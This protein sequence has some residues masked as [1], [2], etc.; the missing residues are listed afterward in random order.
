M[1]THWWLLSLVEAHMIILYT[2]I[3]DTY[4]SNADKKTI[5]HKAI[6]ARHIGP[7]RLS[8]CLHESRVQ[9]ALA[10]LGEPVGELSAALP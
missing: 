8:C 3:S 1:S 2:I 7:G 9:K 5:P 6:R 10:P 4:S